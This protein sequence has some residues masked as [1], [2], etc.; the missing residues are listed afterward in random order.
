MTIAL[1]GADGQLG[2]E[3]LRVLPR[4]DVAPLYYPDFDI[5]RPDLVRAALGAVGPRVV[6]NTAA[7]HRVDECESKP[8][9]AFRVNA[10]AV[11]DLAALCRET[12][13]V[14]VHFSTDYVFDGRKT[15]PYVEED[16]PNPLSIY[17]ASKLAGERFVQASGAKFFLVRTCGLFGLAGCREKGRN[18]VETM[19]ALADRGGPIRVVND[20]TVGPTSAEELA[21]RV[22]ALIGTDRYGLYHLTND[23]SC[24]WYEF[25]RQIFRFL[26]REAE[27]VPVTSEEFGAPARRP[28]FSVLANGQARA[29]GLPAFSPWSEALEFYLKAKGLKK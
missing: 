19:L 16:A 3:L 8:H 25:A 15:T 9:L 24:T 28:R 1:I 23:G 29:A 14:L 13:A 12:D 17:A 5:T 4:E 11:R 21:V 2:T 27:L 18:F 10:L 26:G 22:A 6:I 20:Q 7:F